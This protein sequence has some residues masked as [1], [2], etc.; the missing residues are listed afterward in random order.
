MLDQQPFYTF[1][2]AKCSC[3]FSNI[4][5][6]NGLIKVEK[7][8]PKCKALNIITISNKEIDIQ[9]KLTEDQ[10]APPPGYNESDYWDN[11]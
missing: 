8:C 6:F 7:K 11:K 3:H 10:V 1:R 4:L 5:E 2:C 9:C